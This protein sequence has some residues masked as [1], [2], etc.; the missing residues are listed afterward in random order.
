MY[1]LHICQLALQDYDKYHKYYCFSMLFKFFCIAELEDSRRK[2]HPCWY[3]FTKTFLIWDCFPAWVKIKRLVHMF[4]MDPFVDL[5]IT[6][7]IV[8]NTIFMAMEHHN[9]GDVFV[10][11]LRVGNYVRTTFLYFKSQNFLHIIHILGK[12]LLGVP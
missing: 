6:I 3:K 4:V 11:V 8:I 7:C 2:C 1:L 12:P 9:K 10:I 5:F